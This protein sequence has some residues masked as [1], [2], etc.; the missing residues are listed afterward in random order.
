MKPF[1]GRGIDVDKPVKCYRNLHCDTFS[2]LQGN[3]V[4][5]HARDITLRN[6]DFVV[7]E[8]GR[9]K[10]I[11]EG[12]KNVHAFVVGLI[13]DKPKPSNLSQ[14]RYNPTMGSAFFDSQGNPVLTACHVWLHYPNVFARQ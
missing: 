13:D 3:H 10:A 14:I 9:Q 6:C 5:A 11:K 4:V 1:K 8:A 2:I 12:R 7:R